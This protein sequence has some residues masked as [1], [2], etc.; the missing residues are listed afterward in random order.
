MLHVCSLQ[1]LEPVQKRMLI[2]RLLSS[3]A[4][5]FQ[6]L[7]LAALANAPTAF[8]ASFEDECDTPL[9]TIESNLAQRNLFG[10][11]EGDALVGMVGVGRESTPKLRHK[12]YIRAMY[13]AG[14]HRGKGAGRQ[15]FEHALGFAATLEGV[16]QLS[17][18]VTSGNEPAIA[19]YESMGFVI[20]GI[21]PCA[22]F[23][24]GVFHDNVLMARVLD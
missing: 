9:A 19:L 22:L 13:V 7:R 20:Y 2:R 14:E 4:L 10:A 5:A 8:S 24:D 21:E 11:F 17:L 16:R 18:V 12:G 23:A 15:L 1:T 6:T 3:D